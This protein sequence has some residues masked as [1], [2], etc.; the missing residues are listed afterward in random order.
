MWKNGV[1]WWIEVLF[2]CGKGDKKEARRY[3]DLFIPKPLA[4][5]SN[6]DALFRKV[7]NGIY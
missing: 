4:E 6:D 1:F 5:T 3:L 7:K 2:F